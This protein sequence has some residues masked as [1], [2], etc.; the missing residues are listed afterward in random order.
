LHI[1]PDESFSIVAL[2]WRPGQLTRIHDHVTWCTFGVIQGVE[3]EELFERR[4]QPDRA[5]GNHVGDVSGFATP[6]DI[7]RARNTA[8]EPRSRFMSMELTLRASRPALGVATTTIRYRSKEN[9]DEQAQVSHLDLGG[10]IRRRPE[11]ERGGTAR[12]GWR[13]APRLD[14]S[15]GRVA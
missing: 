14:R 5:E 6:G 15:A 2:V 1:E 11:P 4:S 13:A 8:E 7:H 12:R 3:L 10:R 9:H